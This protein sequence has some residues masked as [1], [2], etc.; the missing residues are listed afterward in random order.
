MLAA[1]FDCALSG[2]IRRSHDHRRWIH[3]GVN[4]T[5]GLE[6]SYGKGWQLSTVVLDLQGNVT[7]NS[8]NDRYT[9]E[10]RA[11]RKAEI[12]DQFFH[13]RLRQKLAGDRD[14]KIVSNY[15]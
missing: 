13:L 15:V 2:G 6:R 4:D 1:G 9:K 3:D 12:P 11:S 7:N 14:T 10:E 5:P 8:Y